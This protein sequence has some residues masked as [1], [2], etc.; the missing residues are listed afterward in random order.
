MNGPRVVVAVEV[1]APVRIVVVGV[2]SAA[3]ARRL[4]DEL[5]DGEHTLAEIRCALGQAW[6]DLRELARES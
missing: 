1:E 5:R 6:E 4:M 3:D 2:E